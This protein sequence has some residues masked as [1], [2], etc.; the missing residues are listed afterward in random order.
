MRR[1][2]TKLP[3]LVF[4][5]SLNW[6]MITVFTSLSVTTL[7]MTPR[8][9]SARSTLVAQPSLIY[10]IDQMLALLWSSPLAGY[11]S[12]S[13]LNHTLLLLMVTQSTL[14]ALISQDCL[15]CRRLKRHGPPQLVLKIKLSP[16]LKRLPALQRPLVSLTRILLLPSWCETPTSTITHISIL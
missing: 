10:R 16:S 2:K 1:W 14:T 15:A 4:W 6:T 5:C 9:S 7:S 11:S 8:R 13:W 3:R 12:A